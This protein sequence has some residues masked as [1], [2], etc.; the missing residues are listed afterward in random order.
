MVDITIDEQWLKK[1]ETEVEH[2]LA[3]LILE[4]VIFCNNGWWYEKEGIPWKKDA[5]SLH[6][7]VNDTFCYGSDAEDITH[8]EIHELYEFWRN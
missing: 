4:N 5:V 7:N 3:H 8:D 1:E 2:K 6:V